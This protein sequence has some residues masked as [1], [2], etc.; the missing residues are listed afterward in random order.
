MSRYWGGRRRGATVNAATGVSESGGAALSPSAIAVP[1]AGA[2]SGKK[3]LA[4]HFACAKHAV[5]IWKK[6]WNSGIFCAWHQP[7]TRC[8]SSAK[9]EEVGF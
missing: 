5:H 2:L 8:G 9:R 4:F 6:D 7:C 1:K 3:H